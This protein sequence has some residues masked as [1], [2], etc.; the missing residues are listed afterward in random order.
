MSNFS[1]SHGVFHL[2]EELSATFIRLEIIVCKLFQFGRVSNLLFGK[3]LSQD[4]VVKI[5]VV[6]FISMILLLDATRIE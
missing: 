6:E 1:F 2:F 4:C 3:G 5:Y